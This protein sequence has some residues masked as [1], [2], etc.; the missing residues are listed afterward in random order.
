MKKSN[1]LLLGGFLFVVFMIVG[2]HIALYA[3]YKNGDYTLRQRANPF[4]D[5][6]MQ[7]FQGIRSV[8]IQNVFAVTIHFD[9]VAAI[10]RVNEHIIKYEQKGDSLFITGHF[11]TNG[12]SDN[13]FPITVTL[14]YNAIIVSDSISRIS[15]F[16]QDLLKSKITIVPNNP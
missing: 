11:V 15:L 3:K 1:K 6:T 5:S 10:E 7:Q 9:S 8:R 16:S 2:I 12:Q 14:P 13:R 4:V